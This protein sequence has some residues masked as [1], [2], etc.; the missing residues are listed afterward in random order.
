MVLVVVLVAVA[1]V[2]LFVRFR[3]EQLCRREFPEHQVLFLLAIQPRLNLHRL[4]VRSAFDVDAFGVLPAAGFLEARE[5]CRC[6]ADDGP[7]STHR[8]LFVAIRCVAR[9]WRQYLRVGC[10]STANVRVLI[11]V[12]NASST[13]APAVASIDG[14]D[15]QR[16]QIA[17][18]SHSCGLVRGTATKR[19]KK[20]LRPSVH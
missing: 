19:S 17:Q 13:K 8:S 12:C 16:L 7:A 6:S 2:A 18:P 4:S 5:G 20:A 14:D 15:Q 3:D 9:R 10:V 11:L 1:V